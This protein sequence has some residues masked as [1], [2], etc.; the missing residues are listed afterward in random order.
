MIQIPQD[1]NCYGIKGLWRNSMIL[2]LI[3]NEQSVP[4]LRKESQNSVD[5]KLHRSLSCSGGG[6]KRKIPSAPAWI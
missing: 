1:G 5:K 3:G 6:V 2:A 4:P